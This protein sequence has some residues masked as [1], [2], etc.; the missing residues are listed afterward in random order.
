[1]NAEPAF[2]SIQEPGAHAVG[3]YGLDSCVAVLIAN[4]DYAMAA[5]YSLQYIAAGHATKALDNFFRQ[6][7]SKLRDSKF[8]VMSPNG[9]PID[10]RPLVKI[11]VDQCAGLRPKDVSVQGYA[12]SQHVD[13]ASSQ[14]TGLI[15][16][17]HTCDAAGGPR[18]YSEGKRV[19]G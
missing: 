5:H 7:G 4:N 10:P 8:V 17:D 18:I 15:E 3:T 13:N 9:I 11:V 19:A 16:Y 1:M 6:N 2:A 14:G 12:T